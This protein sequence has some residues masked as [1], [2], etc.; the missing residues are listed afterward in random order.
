MSHR[1]VVCGM[2]T[3][4]SKSPR[5]LHAALVCER[6]LI[7]DKHTE[8]LVQDLCMFVINQEMFAIKSSAQ[9]SGAF[10]FGKQLSSHKES[11]S[12][13]FIDIEA[14][15]RPG[16]TLKRFRSSIWH[17]YSKNIFIEDMFVIL[18]T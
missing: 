11:D 12:L 1:I 14:S 10:N 16:C 18:C 2:D 5:P 6:Y 3:K 8:I 15:E 7:T 4:T 13:E 17:L 9:W